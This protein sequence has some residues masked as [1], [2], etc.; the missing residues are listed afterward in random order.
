MVLWKGKRQKVFHSD[1]EY[2]L[3]FYIETILNICLW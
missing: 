2:G 3:V 1:K